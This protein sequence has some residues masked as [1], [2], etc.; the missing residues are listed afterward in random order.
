[1]R[2]LFT[3]GKTGMLLTDLES[4]CF[5]IA[6]P[7]QAVPQF[8][9]YTLRAQ[10]RIQYTHTTHSVS[11]C[12]TILTLLT[13]SHNAALYSTTHSVSQC[14]TILYYSL[15]LT[16]QHYTLLLTLSHNAALYSHCSLC[17]TMQHY[18]HTTHSVSQCSTL[19]STT[20]VH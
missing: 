20:L 12:S 14:S 9:R 16:M 18:T 2:I 4:Y 19:P 13:L 7:P 10:V 15:C 6:N 5:N 3:S 8:L 17:L 11:Q 1:M